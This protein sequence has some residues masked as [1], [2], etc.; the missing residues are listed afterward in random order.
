MEDV[1]GIGGGEGFD[2]FEFSV[3]GLVGELSGV[4]SVWTG[5]GFE[6]GLWGDVE[7]GQGDLE[8]EESGLVGIFGFLRA[9]EIAVFEVSV[10]VF[11]EDFA[12]ASAA[13]V[14]HGDGE[15]WRFEGACG[16]GVSD[17]DVGRRGGVFAGFL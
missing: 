3:W 16:L 7:G 12:G 10:W 4:V 1:W 2:E 5:G 6:L 17:G 9:Q 8:G 15:L 11:D 13:S 14:G